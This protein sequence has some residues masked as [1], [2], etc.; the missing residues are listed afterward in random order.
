MIDGIAANNSI[1]VPSGR[2]N[3]GG[4]N[5]V[6]NRAMPKLTGTAIIIAIAAVASVPMI[7]ISAPNSSLTGSHSGLKMN[8]APNFISDCPLPTSSESKIAANTLNT[9]IAARRVTC[10]NIASA[11]A[12]PA[13]GLSAFG[14]RVVV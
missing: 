1:A 7:G 2:F 14:S 9:L 10:R 8:A 11:R 4:D 12:L 13:R 6:R 3:Q 5:S